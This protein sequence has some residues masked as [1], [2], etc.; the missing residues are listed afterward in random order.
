MSVTDGIGF[1]EQMLSKKLK[2][3][4]KINIRDCNVAMTGRLK[5]EKYFDKIS[6]N[7]ITTCLLSERGHSLALL[8]RTHLLHDKWSV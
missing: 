6:E 8:V 2:I 4:S 1:N 3:S 5:R 7:V